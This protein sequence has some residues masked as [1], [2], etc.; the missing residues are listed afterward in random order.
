MDRAGDPARAHPAAGERLV[1]MGAAIGDR[2]QPAIAVAQENALAIY[3]DG[4]WLRRPCVGRLRWE[5]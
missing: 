5:S 2:E 4:L 1:G 3:S